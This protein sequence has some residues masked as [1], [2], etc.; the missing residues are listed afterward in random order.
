MN[1]QVRERM[2]TGWGKSLVI[3]NPIIAISM[4]YLQILFHV[5]TKTARGIYERC[6]L[7]TTVYSFLIVDLQKVR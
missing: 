5:H 1:K 2:K 6:L 3:I 7:Q 4:N